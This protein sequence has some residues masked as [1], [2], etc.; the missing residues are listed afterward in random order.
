MVMGTP[1]S[2]TVMSVNERVT[3]PGLFSPVTVTK[4]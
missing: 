2:G 3:R 4:T 1:A